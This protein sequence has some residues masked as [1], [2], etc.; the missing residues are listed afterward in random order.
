MGVTIT[1]G[2]TPDK[3]INIMTGKANNLLRR[4][5]MAFIYIDKDM[6]RK[7]LVTMIRPL[8]EYAAVVWSPHTKKNIRKLERVQRA[9][10]KMAPELRDLEYEERLR[11]MGLTTLEN[12]RERGDLINI[13]KML[14]G[15]DKTGEDLIKRDT[16]ITRGH[17]K[18]L[19][20][21]I[22]SH[23][24]LLQCGMAWMRL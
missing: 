1:E 6:M 17:E 14:H 3:H 13:Y 15:M 5:K 9:A 4:I 2:L 7:V 8:L 18:K 11:E 16:G 24:E 12:R 20:R 22:A 10:T 21:S 19:K 23:T